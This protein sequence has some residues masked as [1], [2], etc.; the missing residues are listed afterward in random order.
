MEYEKEIT[1]RIDNAIYNVLKEEM[2][3]GWSLDQLVPMMESAMY[4]AI[5]RLKEGK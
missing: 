4:E 3:R 1:E 2:A 5:E